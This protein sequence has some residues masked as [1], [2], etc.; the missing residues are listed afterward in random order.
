[1][2]RL[3]I[4]WLL[5]VTVPLAIRGVLARDARTARDL[6]NVD[7]STDDNGGC[8]YAGENEIDTEL[9]EIYQILNI[10]TVLVDEWDHADEA[11]RLL[12]A[13]FGT[14]NDAQR[15]QLTSN[16]EEVMDFLRNG[17]LFNGE[18]PY[19]FC[20]SNWLTRQRVADT[21]LDANGQRI[22]TNPPQ[23]TQ[24]LTIRELQRRDGTAGYTY[25]W[26]SRMNAY[27]ALPGSSPRTYCDR[28]ARNKGVT[29]E[30]IALGR[31]YIPFTS[32]TI[33]PNGFENRWRRRNSAA[34]NPVRASAVTARSQSIGSLYP[35]AMTL[36]HELFHLVLGNTNT[37]VDP[38][39]L[40]EEYGVAGMLGLSA[41]QALRNPE[42]MALVAVAYDITSHEGQVGQDFVEFHT[43]YAT[44]G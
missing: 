13:F 9:E 8:A 39:T 4:A 18:K 34:V 25:W 23:N 37:F 21:V 10:G 33:C 30:P 41:D 2:V 12:T 35:T 36:F 11:K 7:F 5:S 26:T 40:Y 3:S 19:L 31:P 42:S 32:I 43:G 20:N 17:R 44:R 16:Y 15:A 29:T 24:A 22:F 1:M 28:D 38:N 6:F 14:P 27:L